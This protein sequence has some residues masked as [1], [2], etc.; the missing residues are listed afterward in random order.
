MKVQIALGVE[1]GCQQVRAQRI[2]AIPDPKSLL[3]RLRR[4]RLY[5]VTELLSSR[6]ICSQ[7]RG[8]ASQPIAAVAGIVT[9]GADIL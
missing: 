3:N 9:L 1:L 4:G 7:R 5:A 8:L 2:T 6:T